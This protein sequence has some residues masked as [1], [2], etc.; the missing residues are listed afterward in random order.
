VNFTLAQGAKRVRHAAVDA[1]DLQVRC[2]G[3]SVRGFQ[4]AAIQ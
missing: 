2:P 3:Y 4:Q 1:A